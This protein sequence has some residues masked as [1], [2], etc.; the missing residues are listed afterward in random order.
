MK[1]IKY[2]SLFAITFSAL[3]LSGC[4]T[5]QRGTAM[6]IP[7]ASNPERADVSVSTGQRGTTPLIVTL[8][9]N[10]T[11]QVTISKEGYKTQYFTL[12]PKVC[13]EGV[14]A[15]SMN[16]ILGGVVGIGVDAVSGANLNLDP[17]HIFAELEAEK[18]NKPVAPVVDVVKINCPLTE[19]QEKDFYN[20]LNEVEKDNKELVVLE[21]GNPYK[22]HSALTGLSSATFVGVRLK[23]KKTEKSDYEYSMR[24]CVINKDGKFEH[25][26][27][28]PSSTVDVNKPF[29][30]MQIEPA[31]L[32]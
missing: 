22:V 10:E 2:T 14:A 18:S 31:S 12:T 16:L 13:V 6:N 17:D 28:L 3:L 11:V 1:F 27:W 24:T 32:K 19:Q 4:A 25:L 20:K 21:W 23:I 7:I 8:K 5:I 26:N 9:R 15:G 30:Q 29:A